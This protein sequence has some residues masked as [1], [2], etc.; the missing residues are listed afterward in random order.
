MFPCTENPGSARA[1]YM[2]CSNE[3]HISLC[4]VTYYPTP[5]L[6][7][8]EQFS[9]LMQLEH[10]GGALGSSPIHMSGYYLHEEP[11]LHGYTFS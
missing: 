11:F 8:V 5:C 10:E 7:A 4:S 1:G 2:L 9:G 6:N 3:P